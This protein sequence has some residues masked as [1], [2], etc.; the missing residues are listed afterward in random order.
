MMVRT[1][2][3]IPREAC[4]ARQVHRSYQ[5]HKFIL[6]EDVWAV[7][8]IEDVTDALRKVQL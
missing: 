6:Y 1:R 5:R 3:V 7:P 4:R 2:V 8:G